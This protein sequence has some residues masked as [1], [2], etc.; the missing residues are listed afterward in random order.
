MAASLQ[1]R[2]SIRIP[3]KGKLAVILC[4]NLLYV[5]RRT[6]QAYEAQLLSDPNILARLTRL[7]PHMQ[8]QQQI[9][10]NLTSSGGSNSGSELDQS[11]VTVLH[12]PNGVP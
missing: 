4:M 2:S 1:E 12:L 11:T 5:F 8:P 7:P 6:L 3:S 9:P 10:Q